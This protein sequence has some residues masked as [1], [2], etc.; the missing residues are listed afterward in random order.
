MPESD[1]YTAGYR[2]DAVYSSD[3]NDERYKRTTV[4]RYKVGH[5]QVERV[6]QVERERVED[7]GQE[8][9]D[10]RGGHRSSN[11]MIEV[12]RRIYSPE[13]PR[14]AVDITEHT[15]RYYGDDGRLIVHETTKD[16]DHDTGRHSRN[17]EGLFQVQ[18]RDERDDQIIVESY[19]KDRHGDGHG[20]EVERWHKETEYYEPSIPPPAPIVIRPRPVEQNIILQDS[21]GLSSVI[22]PHQGQVALVAHDRERP[23]KKDL[24]EENDYYYERRE[25]REVVPYRGEREDLAAGQ[26]GRRGRNPDHRHRHYTHH[27]DYASDGELDSEDD[28]Y[29][30][31]KTVIR[32]E[33]PPSASERRRHLA[34][35][36][37]AGAGIGALL[38][39]RRNQDGELPEHRGRKV[40]AGAALGA[41]GTEVMKRAHSTYDD[42]FSDNHSRPASRE[43]SRSPSHHSTLKTGLGI[44][45]AALAVAGAAKYLQ[46]SRI[47]REEQNRGRSL[48]RYSDDERYDSRL[49]SRTSRKAH[50]RASSVAKVAAGTAAV[51]GIVHHFRSKSRG[52]SGK[53]R[54]HSR[55]RTGAEVVAAGLAG[56]AAK[57]LYDKHRD[58]K[59]DERD[60]ALANE[61]Y[62]EERR[63]R[64]LRSRPQSSSRSQS[65]SL[66][67]SLSRSRPQS[68]SGARAGVTLSSHHPDAGYSPRPGADSKLGLVEYGAWPLYSGPPHPD[69]RTPDTGS[70]YSRYS[71]AAEDSECGGYR[72]R[73]HTRDQGS[74]D[75]SDVRNDAED[76]SFA[77]SSIAGE[78]GNSKKVKDNRSRDHSNLQDFA[79][80]GAGAVAAAAAAPIG[81]KK[82]EDRKKV[83]SI[84]SSEGRS[85]HRGNYG[86]YDRDKFREN[87]E[88]S[89]EFYKDRDSSHNSAASLE[90]DS[91]LNFTPETAVGPRDNTTLDK[92][93]PRD[94]DTVEKNMFVVVRRRNRFT[95]LECKIPAQKKDVA[96]WIRNQFRETGRMLMTSELLQLDEDT[97]QGS[98]KEDEVRAADM[99]DLP[100]SRQSVWHLVKS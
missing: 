27:R 40:I 22:M 34:E 41:L 64:Q 86:S 31:K 98:R 100:G 12:D 24:R 87:R 73:S 19:S 3:E 39:S 66:S 51:A 47:D 44:A 8:S 13:R 36:A 81:I 75:A 92:S 5:G 97:D 43:R 29:I 54:S 25:R 77:D 62:E 21:P 55:L 79:A 7:D 14:S 53:S 93:P 32:R 45:A 48:H 90:Q 33:I 6:E 37:L 1:Y 67:R 68:R 23:R 26:L 99:T 65:R 72:R 76:P 11:N 78:Y 50:S 38:S 58:K 17:R 42:R 4:R 63:N 59:E 69:S 46:S 35:G 74:L 20:G 96:A 94:N 83:G 16:L 89:L 28:Y 30:T 57:K 49:S 56:A 18:S 71:S 61:E 9:W 10:Q 15:R 82:M 70:Y 88:A 60:R 84:D 80:A 95:D 85:V 91:I 52:Q 2:R